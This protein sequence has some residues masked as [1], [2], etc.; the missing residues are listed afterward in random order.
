MAVDV[1]WATTEDAAAL[2]TILCE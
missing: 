2:A 1:R